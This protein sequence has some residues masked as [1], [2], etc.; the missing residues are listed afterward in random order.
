MFQIVNEQAPIVDDTQVNSLFDI[1]NKQD[2]MQLKAPSDNDADDNQSDDDEEAPLD[3][4]SMS[5]VENMIDEITKEK[6]PKKKK[7]LKKKKPV[8]SHQVIDNHPPRRFGPNSNQGLY[9]MIGIENEEQRRLANI[10]DQISNVTNKLALD[11]GRYNIGDS[12][13]EA[14]SNQ[15]RFK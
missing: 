4:Q 6:V 5:N 1:K 14:V 15:D 11:N 9:P 8:P 7:L 12:Q 2:T 3:I 10:A 13:I